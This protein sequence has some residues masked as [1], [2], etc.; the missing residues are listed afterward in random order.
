MKSIAA[1]IVVFAGSV[2]WGIGTLSITWSFAAGG[3]RAPGDIGAYGGMA[4]AAVGVL[5]LVRAV[6]SPEDRR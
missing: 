3:N 6:A 5:L 2:L 1:A 4:V